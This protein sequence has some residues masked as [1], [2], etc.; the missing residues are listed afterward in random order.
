MGTSSEGTI[1]A[2]VEACGIP[3]GGAYCRSPRL[4]VDGGGTA[5]LAFIASRPEGERPM[6]ARSPGGGVRSFEDTRP[7]AEWSPLVTA[8]AVAP[9]QGG[10]LAAWISGGEGE[11][12][13]RLRFARCSAAGFGS[14]HEAL[15]AA[16]P[17]QV[18][19]CPAGE[20]FAAAWVGRDFGRLRIAGVL[21]DRDGAVTREMRPVEGDG[22]LGHPALASG[23]DGAPWLAWQELTRDGASRIVAGRFG[24]PEECRSIVEHRDGGTAA[25][26]ALAA[27]CAGGVWISWHSDVDAAAGPGLVRWIEAA[28]LDRT[29][30]VSRPASPLPGIERHGRAEDQG[31]EFPTLVPGPDGR[32]VVVGRGSQGLYRQDLGERGCGPRLRLDEPGWACRGIS[33]AAAAP[34]GI[35][36][37]TRE[38]A[39]L[40]VRFVPWGGPGPGSGPAL[41]AERTSFR[42]PA[43]ERASLPSPR[44]LVSLGSAPPTMLIF[45][46]RVL[47]GDIHQHT[48]ASD[49]TG[50]RPEAFHRARFRYGDDLAA[51]ADH[52]SFVGKQTPKGEWHEQRGEA[53]AAYVPGEFVTLHAF[54]WTGRMHPGPGH[55]VV[56]P[57]AGG[58]PVLSRDDPETASSAGLVAAC[59]DL[60]ALAVPHHV[61]W[62]GA[63]AAAHDPLVQ[64]VWEIV[65][66]HGA[67]ER[68]GAGPI[69]TRGDD[70]PGQFAAEALDAGLR[71]GFVGGSD[72]HGLAWHHGICRIEDSHRTGLTAVFASPNR[73][74][75]LDALRRR[76][77]YATSGAKIGL[78]FEAGG[79][80]MGS[81]LTVTGPVRFRVVVRA[82]APIARVRLVTNGGAER[83]LPAKR[84]S[85]D[86]SGS[87]PAPEVSAFH[88]IRVEQADGHAAW[89]S[90]IWLDRV[91]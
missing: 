74:S 56:Y 2:G 39:G 33:D 67:Y 57:P 38:R 3:D 23:G 73:E 85:A 6:L 42:I 79:R 89:S 36:L 29:G 45:G 87:L 24:A 14:V 72:G 10:V 90:P 9:A 13:V 49:G 77:C 17:A 53:D 40:L 35:L 91:G 55:K 30:R 78:W 58:G 43:T 20:G 59:R 70:K 83:G 50:T 31:F 64:P 61:G 51:V 47:F 54:E 60:G 15:G 84:I 18:A 75:V 22:I 68:P 65:S 80:P 46:R 76:R 4:A 1:C 25:R 81:E 41:S 5:W 16:G 66:A 63:D 8:V 34:E 44:S 26:P 86:C 11:G 62:T 82:T 37:A 88:F 69:G 71:F 28:H 32:L 12:G 27:D 19:V 21:L 48:A 52:E 7:L